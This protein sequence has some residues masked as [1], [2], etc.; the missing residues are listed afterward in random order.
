MELLQPAVN[1]PV[2]DAVHRVLR[3]R[4]TG[5]C[6]SGVTHGVNSS[7]DEHELASRFL[8]ALS[9]RDASPKD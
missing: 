5:F 8:A 6:F 4:S 2:V 9:V 7:G 1:T 3:T